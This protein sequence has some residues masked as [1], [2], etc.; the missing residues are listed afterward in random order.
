[1]KNTVNTSSSQPRKGKGVAIAQHRA[2]IWARELPDYVFEVPVL[3]ALIS[4][5]DGR[6]YCYPTQQ[7]I[8]A[9]AKWLPERL[10]KVDVKTASPE[11]AKAIKSATKRV[12]QATKVLEGN[13]LIRIQRTPTRYSGTRTEYWLRPDSEVGS[14][15]FGPYSEVP[16]D[17]TLES[18][19]PY[20]EVGSSY[21]DKQY[22]NYNKDGGQAANHFGTAFSETTQQGKAEKE[23]GDIML[24]D[25]YGF[26]FN[27]W[28]T[29]P[30]DL[31]PAMLANM[32]RW[33]LADIYGQHFSPKEKELG[34]LS[35]F[36]AHTGA[37][38]SMALWFVTAF[39]SD[40]LDYVRENTNSHP[41][42]YKF[43]AKTPDL[44][45]LVKHSDH[46]VNFYLY[47]SACTWLK[48][49]YGSVFSFGD[50]EI[51][52]TMKEVRHGHNRCL[53]IDRKSLNELKAESAAV[54]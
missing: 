46:A 32:Y 25:P 52:E 29:L 50:K 43:C 26:G 21:E 18:F 51:A 30:E 17:T 36:L 5:I 49:K 41:D 31:T 53:E 39:W 22:K 12:G 24:E 2:L 3:F 38:S 13:G 16:L 20:S 23:D 8:A 11:D 34:Q 15:Q 9:D 40:F 42:M 14:K 28:L 7:Q 44:G 47:R 27:P 10:A 4:R 45:V 48:W 6:Y 19:G 37:F 35:D 54:S 1:M 33:R